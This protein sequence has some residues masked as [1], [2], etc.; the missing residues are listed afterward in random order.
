MFIVKD[1]TT[2]I[3]KAV[4][5]LENAGYGKKRILSL[6]KTSSDLELQLDGYS[7]KYQ[8]IAGNVIHGETQGF[9]EEKHIGPIFDM[10]ENIT[11]I[12]HGIENNN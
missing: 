12:L 3:K 8:I 1:Y 7:T 9:L 4:K 2:A 10:F 11:S 5:A 6:Q